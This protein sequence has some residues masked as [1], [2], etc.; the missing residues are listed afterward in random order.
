[1][2]D[3]TLA[4]LRG[5][6]VAAIVA[7]DLLIAAEGRRC[8]DCNRRSGDLAQCADGQWRGPSCRRRHEA[9]AERGAGVQLP[10]AEGAS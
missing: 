1:M 5:R 3:A 2:A 4:A 6:L 8:A 10:I 7:V 9:A